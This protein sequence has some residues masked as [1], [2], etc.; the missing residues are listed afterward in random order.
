MSRLYGRQYVVEWDDEVGRYHVTLGQDS[1]GFHRTTDG[2]HQLAAMHARR[3][4]LFCDQ[5]Y[6][7]TI[8]RREPVAAAA[9]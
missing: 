8:V 3:V 9:R 2:A 7:V 1:I 5:A 4:S 6:G